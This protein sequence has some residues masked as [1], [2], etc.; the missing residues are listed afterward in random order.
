[1]IDFDELNDLIEQLQVES[2]KQY[3]SMELSEM[4]LVY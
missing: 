3:S 1:M 4:K 2:N